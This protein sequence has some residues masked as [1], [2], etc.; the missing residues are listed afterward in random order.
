MMNI[1]AFTHINGRYLSNRKREINSESLKA[2]FNVKDSRVAR[3]DTIKYSARKIRRSTSSKNALFK[4]NANLGK[5]TIS[6]IHAWAKRVSEQRSSW[7]ELFISIAEQRSEGSDVPYPRS[8]IYYQATVRRVYSRCINNRIRFIA[9]G[10]R[11]T[12]SEGHKP[13]F[14]GCSLRLYSRR[15]RALMH[16]FADGIALTSPFHSWLTIPRLPPSRLTF[17]F[18]FFCTTSHPR[19]HKR[20]YV[21]RLVRMKERYSSAVEYS[22][23]AFENV[24]RKWNS[25]GGSFSEKIVIIFSENLIIYPFST[26]KNKKDKSPN[27]ISMTLT[28]IKDLLSCY[29]NSDHDAVQKVIQFNFTFTCIVFD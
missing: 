27:F 20:F 21:L 14:S 22:A 16:P 25:C 5:S 8:R 3:R 17:L 15:C 29:K 19:S 4:F 23:A 9:L 1:N 12:G 11:S 10:Y 28:Y 26:N 13:R 18:F 24:I 7:R 6:C 2:L